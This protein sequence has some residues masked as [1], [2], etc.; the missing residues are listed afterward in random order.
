M[1]YNKTTPDKNTFF[2]LVLF[3]FY[4]ESCPFYQVSGYSYVVSYT[5][6]QGSC[7]FSLVTGNFLPGVFY[8]LRRICY[9]LPRN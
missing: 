6:Y 7:P 9:L 4:Q 8:I 5:F 3:T 2:Y 1:I